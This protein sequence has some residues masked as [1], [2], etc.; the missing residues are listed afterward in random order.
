[1]LPISVM[2]THVRALK[3]P[4][5]E[6]GNNISIRRLTFRN[7]CWGR[8]FLLH[9]CLPG[10]DFIASRWC[11]NIEKVRS[12]EEKT[13]SD[14][15]PAGEYWAGGEAGTRSA[16]PMRASRVLTSRGRVG[17]LRHSAKLRWL[18][19]DSQSGTCHV[20]P[21]RCSSPQCFTCTL[22]KQFPYRA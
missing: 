13:H 18:M 8:K 21:Q 14:P 6:L 1:M 15:E 22:L 12:K 5:D 16:V 7:A 2:L 17:L 3:P 19:G 10:F 4:S 20:L 11:V 9:L